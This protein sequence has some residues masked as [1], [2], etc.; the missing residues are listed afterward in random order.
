MNLPR[1]CSSPAR[2]HATLIGIDA[3]EHAGI[4]R[5][6]REALVVDLEIRRVLKSGGHAIFPSKPRRLPHQPVDAAVGRARQPMVGLDARAHRRASRLGDEEGGR[7]AFERVVP[8][9]VAG[10]GVDRLV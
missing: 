9:V 3:S 5:Q 8:V 2:S 7:E 1:D 10:N 4:H 6:Q